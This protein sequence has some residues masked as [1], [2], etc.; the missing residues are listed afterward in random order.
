MVPADAANRML[1]HV[2]PSH[3]AGDA[4]GAAIPD[5]REM[6]NNRMKTWITSLIAVVTWTTTTCAAQ[7]P[8][9]MAEGPFQPDWS[10]LAAY[11]CPEWFRDAK[12][13]IWAH[14]GRQC[15]P[16]HG[17]WYARNMYIEGGADYKSH[18]AQYGHPS[19]DGFKDVIHQWKAA[20]V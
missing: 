19:T 9:P 7:R 8:L 2:L 18:L 12:F 20:H 17:D 6:R 10:S 11:R 5:S 13:G 14:W 16:E 15:E 3:A 4:A 1:A